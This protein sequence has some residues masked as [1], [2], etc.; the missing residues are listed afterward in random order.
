MYKILIFSYLLSLTTAHAASLN[1]IITSVNTQCPQ[2]NRLVIK[3]SLI[4]L[5][6]SRFCTGTFTTLL[7][8]DCSQLSCN[9]LI[10]ISD[11]LSDTNSGSVIGR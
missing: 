9:T 10:S 6:S 4:E 2:V 3:K 11:N 5:H 7:L 8:N 1:E